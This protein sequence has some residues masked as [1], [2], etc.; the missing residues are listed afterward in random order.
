[1]KA[2][3]LKKENN[4]LILTGNTYPS[5]EWLKEKF[6]AKWDNNQKAWIIDA[7]VKFFSDCYWEETAEHTLIRNWAKLIEK[8]EKKVENKEDKLVEIK[9]TDDWELYIYETYSILMN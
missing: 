3:N 6:K 9:E 2:V 4:K 1:M 8:E 5:K 7:N